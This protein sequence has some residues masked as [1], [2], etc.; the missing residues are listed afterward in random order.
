MD[1]I[2]EDKLQVLGAALI[3]QLT[4]NVNTLVDKATGDLKSL[5]DGLDGWTAT[6]TLNKPKGQ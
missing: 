4:T 2:N 6:I 3:T 1:L 5:L